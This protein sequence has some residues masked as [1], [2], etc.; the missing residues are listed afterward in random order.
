MSWYLADKDGADDMD[1]SPFRTPNFLALRREWYARL[2]AEGFRDIE[3]TDWTTGESKGLVGISDSAV[4][5]RY[6]SDDAH[7]FRLAGEIAESPGLET[8]ERWRAA[9]QLHADGAPYAEIAR[10]MGV[11]SRT[12]RRWCSNIRRERLPIPRGDGEEPA[13]A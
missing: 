12:V 2:A 8:P 11:C 10:R 5:R 6:S 3:A 1:D 7:Y 4:R 9:W 13:E